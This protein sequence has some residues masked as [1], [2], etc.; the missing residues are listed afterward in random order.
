MALTNIAPSVAQSH[1]SFAV[2]DAAI[3]AAIAFAL[4]VFVA[5]FRTFDQGGLKF[6]YQVIDVLVACVII[7]VGRLGL[8]LSASVPIA[9]VGLGVVGVAVAVASFVG[10]TTAAMPSVFLAV[11]W[12]GAGVMLVVRAGPAAARRPSCRA[13]R[14][15]RSRCGWL[16]P[17]S[18]PACSPSPSCCRSCRSPTSG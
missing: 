11:V 17:G 7:F 13:A 10:G 2:K 15:S 1:W 18:A 16:F 9:T 3:T 4:G 14:P 6:D 8:T 12:G 5:G